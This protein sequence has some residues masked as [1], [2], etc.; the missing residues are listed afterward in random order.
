MLGSTRANAF[1][2]EDLTLLNQVAAQ[3]GVAL[4]NH[5]AAMEIEALK[6]RLAE[7]KKYL[8]GEVSCKG[9]FA[10]IVGESPAL[11]QVLEQVTTVAASEATVLILGET[12]TG[13][14]L[15]ARAIHSTP[16]KT[17]REIPTKAS[18]SDSGGT[19]PRHIMR[20]TANASSSASAR[21][22]RGS[23][24]CPRGSLAGP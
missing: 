1:Q 18:T 20:R 19:H 10:E 7:E 14:E 24:P 6:E 21:G 11:R 22:R 4:E 15:I 2:A 9:L 16:S 3:L 12:G 17:R 5:R 23:S 8:D 13:K